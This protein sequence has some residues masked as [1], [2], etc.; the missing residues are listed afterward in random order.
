MQPTLDHRRR[1]PAKSTDVTYAANTRHYERR[2]PREGRVVAGLEQRRCQPRT[3]A[4]W[5]DRVSGIIR[6]AFVLG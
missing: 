5:S 6:R 3:F 4:D 2:P 1:A